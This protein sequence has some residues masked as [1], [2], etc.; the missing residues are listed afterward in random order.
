ME[1]KKLT[2]EQARVLIALHELEALDK[3]SA[4][5]ELCVREISSC[6]QGPINSLIKKGKIERVKPEK[7]KSSKKFPL[8][9]EAEKNANSMDLKKAK[10]NLKELAENC[11]EIDEKTSMNAGIFRKMFH[12]EF[13]NYNKASNSIR[14]LYETGFFENNSFLKQYL[15]L[16]YQNRNP[17]KCFLKVKLSKDFIKKSK[18]TAFNT[19]QMQ[20]YIFT[21]SLFKES[22]ANKFMQYSLTRISDSLKRQQEKID[23]LPS[24]EI[25]KIAKDSTTAILESNN[26][27]A[28]VYSVSSV[29]TAVN[30]I[31]LLASSLEKQTLLQFSEQIP[32]K[33]FN[34]IK[35]N[36]FAL[37][38]ELNL[39]EK[40]SKV[41]QNLERAILTVCHSTKE[42][43][44]SFSFPQVKRILSNAGIKTENKAIIDIHNKLVFQEK[45]K[46]K[47]VGNKFFYELL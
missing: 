2:K 5:K 45:L 19:E 36:E 27:R 12:E 6:T 16:V 9:G 13:F 46:Q 38:S 4:I 33:E 40:L 17:I 39:Q 30:K 3:K 10:E 41:K 31:E 24:T 20:K 47:T 44:I 7:E 8:C 25:N 43:G 32:P 15:V 23:I 28:R 18:A 14:M 29:E 35:N 34:E 21:L 37:M 42:K 26:P 22:N 1:E 11:L